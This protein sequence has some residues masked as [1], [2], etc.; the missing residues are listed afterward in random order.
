VLFDIH[1]VFF[2]ES[3]EKVES[4]LTEFGI[5]HTEWRTARRLGGWNEYKRGVMSEADYWNRLRATP[6][7][8]KN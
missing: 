5:T 7:S 4:L 3:D 1:G 8:Q 2:L 6:V